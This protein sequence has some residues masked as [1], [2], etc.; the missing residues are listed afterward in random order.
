MKSLEDKAKIEK[1]TN[2]KLNN[3]HNNKINE[4]NQRS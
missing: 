2:D 4:L 3:A 1:E